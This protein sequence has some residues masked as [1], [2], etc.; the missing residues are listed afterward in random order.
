MIWRLITRAAGPI[1]ALTIGASVGFVLV[2]GW[3]AA[4]P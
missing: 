1:L 4:T 3:R 2:F